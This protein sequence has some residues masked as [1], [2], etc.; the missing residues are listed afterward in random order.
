M[1]DS[2]VIMI[3]MTLRNAKCFVSRSETKMAV[4]P[5]KTND[6]AKFLVTFSFRRAKRSFRDCGFGFR[7]RPEGFSFAAPQQRMLA[8][9]LNERKKVT[10]NSS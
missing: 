9:G 5:L 4:K 10:Q 6:H 3:S 1:P 7:R 2:D 8:M